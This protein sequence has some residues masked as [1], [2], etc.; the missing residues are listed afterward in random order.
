[1]PT[2]LKIDDL[3]LEKAMK[4]GKHLTKKE[5]VSK[6]LEEYILRREQKKIINLFNSI[7]FLPGYDYKKQRNKT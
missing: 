4:I 2:N 5:A 7:E 3:L 6:A 1:M